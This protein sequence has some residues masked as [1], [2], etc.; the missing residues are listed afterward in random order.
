[1]SFL[2]SEV[3]LG[4]IRRYI[5]LFGSVLIHRVERECCRTARSK[6]GGHVTGRQR[7]MP[8]LRRHRVSL[9][10]VRKRCFVSCL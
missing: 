5:C 1:M 4:C 8:D 10:Q 3:W 6:T 2:L 7:H 9:L